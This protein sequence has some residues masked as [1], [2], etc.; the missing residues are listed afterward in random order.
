MENIF[1]RLDAS[2]LRLVDDELLQFLLVAVAELGE[3]KTGECS[4]AIHCREKKISASFSSFVSRI[5]VGVRSVVYEGVE[6]R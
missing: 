6:S 3:V 5:E 1:T 2:F 4:G